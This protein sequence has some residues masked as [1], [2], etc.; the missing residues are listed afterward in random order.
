MEGFK[1]RLKYLRLE[2]EKSQKE[3]AHD[4]GFVQSAIAYW[5]SGQRVPNA[6]AVIALAKYFDVTTDYLLGLED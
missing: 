1:E 6:L 2:K 3:V 5:E 4:T